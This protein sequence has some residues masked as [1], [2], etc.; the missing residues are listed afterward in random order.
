MAS[1]NIGGIQCNI[2]HS[3]NDPGIVRSWP[4]S[5]PQVTVRFHCGWSDAPSLAANL[6]GYVKEGDD[7]SIS[8]VPPYRLPWAQQ[9]YCQEISDEV[10]LT[11]RG[12]FDG[13]TTYDTSMITAVFAPLRYQI[14]AEEPGGRADASGLAYTTTRFRVS[15]EI[16]NPPTG[17]YFIAPFGSGA[18]QISQG[19]VGFV[20][21]TV[22]VN[23]TRHWRAFL[24][25]DAAIQLVGCVND[26]DITLADRTFP[27]G[28]LLFQGMEAEPNNDSNGYPV[29]EINYTFAG[30][31]TIE[32]NEVQGDDGAYHLLNTKNDGTGDFPFPYQDFSPLFG[33]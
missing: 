29:F 13:W 4:S 17:A 16:Y 27:T 6:L 22:D 1:L 23:M 12:N 14:S 24:P 9:L 19:S 7:G 31:A 18:Q 5:G 30:H 32:W 8:R 28:T 3:D 33:D 21:P 15:S 25:L 26:S 10:P 2:A 11:S 20:R